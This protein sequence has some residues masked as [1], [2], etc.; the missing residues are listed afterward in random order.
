MS[1]LSKLL[2]APSLT[3]PVRIFSYDHNI[4][5]FLSNL[6]YH[7][8]AIFGYEDCGLL[9]KDNECKTQIPSFFAYLAFSSEPVFHSVSERPKLETEVNHES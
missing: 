1:Q 2:S 7:L 4:R 9:I 5:L 3:F 8:A 6:R